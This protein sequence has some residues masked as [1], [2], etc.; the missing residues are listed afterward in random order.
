[1]DA[2]Y[3]VIIAD[4]AEHERVY[5]EIQCNNKFLAIVSQEEGEDRLLVELPGLGL[6]EDYVVRQVRLTDF[7]DVLNQAAMKLLGKS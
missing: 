4:D 3:S 5:A 2:R 6:D 1:M 7:I